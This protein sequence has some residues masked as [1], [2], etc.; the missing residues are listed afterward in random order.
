MQAASLG[1]M[2]YEERKRVYKRDRRHVAFGTGSCIRD[3]TVINSE[4]MQSIDF[5]CLQ[6]RTR[7]LLATT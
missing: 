4:T 1:F 2:S 6:D 7:N 5:P 3:D